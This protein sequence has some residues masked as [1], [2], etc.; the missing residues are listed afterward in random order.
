LQ[1]FA[2]DHGRLA[3]PE[4]IGQAIDPLK[5]GFRRKQLTRKLER[6]E[7]LHGVGALM[8]LKR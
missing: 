6:R 4:T 8:V 2:G 1:L 7:F 3:Q 5:Q